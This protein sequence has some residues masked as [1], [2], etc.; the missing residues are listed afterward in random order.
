M[1][2]MGFD[3][4]DCTTTEDIELCIQKWTIENL[5][6]STQNRTYH[7]AIQWLAARLRRAA[8]DVP[9]LNNTLL[10]IEPLDV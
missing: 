10:N 7:Q 2:K 6:S 8:Q 4:K 9:V 5:P 3:E 1:T